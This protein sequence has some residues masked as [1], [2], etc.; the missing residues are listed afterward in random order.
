MKGVSDVDIAIVGAGLAGGALA[1]ALSGRGLRLA[2]IESRPLTAPELPLQRELDAFD[3]RVSALN[4]ESVSLLQRLE[5]WQSVEQYRCCAYHHMTVWDAEGTGQIEFDAA[6]VDHSAL[7]YIVENRAVIS[8]LI[9]RLQDAGDLRVVAPGKLAA[10]AIEDDTVNLQLEDGDTL[11]ARLLV[12][13]D[14]ALSSVRSLLQFRTR[15]WDYGHRALVATVETGRPHGN[16]AWQRFLPSG[17]LAFLP[18]PGENGRHF[19]SIVWSLRDSLADEVL[20]LDDT[21]FCDRL[22]EAFEQRLG[23]VVGASP[24]AAFP[25]RQR[26]AVDY[27]RPRV[28]LVGDAAHTIHPLAGQGINLGFKDVSVLAEEVLAAHGRG[29]DPGDLAVLRRYQ[30]RRK[31]EN[32]LMMGAMDTFKRLFEQESLPLRWL[33]SAGMNAVH[34]AGPLK[35][36]IM[37]RAM[38]LGV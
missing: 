18:L 5:A 9:A 29:V 17:P 6:D 23:R 25:L 22:E 11:R 35:Q 26:H 14:G 15:E 34:R 8:G 33:R 37:R 36:E 12:A 19:C 2:L 32:L 24:R 1:A 13:A 4:P 16:T 38:G 21:A 31:G 28:A 10:V 7:G 30:R 20:A 3:S 27:I